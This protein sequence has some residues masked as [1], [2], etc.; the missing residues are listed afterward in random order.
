MA[1][2]KKMKCKRC[3]TDEDRIHGFC[4]TYCEDMDELE[5]EIKNLKKQLADSRSCLQ[6]QAA[7]I[8]EMRRHQAAII[9]GPLP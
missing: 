8:P 5:Q 3:G 1:A 4:S 9:K 2:M 7:E 6:G